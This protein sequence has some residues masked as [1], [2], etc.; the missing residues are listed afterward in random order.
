MAAHYDNPEEQQEV[1]AYIDELRAQDDRSCVIMIAAR[2]EYL[3]ER[4]I[5]QRLIEPRSKRRKGF[6]PSFASA[7]D[8]SYR[9]GILHSTHADALHALRSIRNAAAHFDQPMSLED[10]RQDVENFCRPWTEG[11]VGLQFHS[12]RERE[13]NRAP[14]PA[15]G[16]FLV[17]ASIFFVFFTPL[18]TVVPRLDRLHW[19]AGLDS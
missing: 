16:L 4:A 1:E 14:T 3:L 18:S 7:I 6:V 15:R 13:L 5:D 19:L 11:R 17:G 10:R 12:F 9:L 2:I 8:L